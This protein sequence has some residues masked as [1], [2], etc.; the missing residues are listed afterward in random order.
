MAK[1]NGVKEICDHL[2]LS[3]LTVMDM[4][5]KQN[6]PAKKNKEGIWVTDTAKVDKFMTAGRKPAAPKKDK[7]IINGD[8]DKGL[9][10]GR[11]S[12]K[13]EKGDKDKGLKTDKE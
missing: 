9:K 11:K 13:A 8:E 2:K 1:L 6:F 4:I 5:F 12:K 7:K 10:T 3:E